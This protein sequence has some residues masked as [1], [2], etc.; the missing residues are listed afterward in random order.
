MKDGGKIDS[1]FYENALLVS[2]FSLS[3]VDAAREPHH[4]ST[5]Y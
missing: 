2:I 1:K 5:I 3:V 4:F